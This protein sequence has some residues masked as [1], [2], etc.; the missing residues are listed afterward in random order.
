MVKDA[1]DEK[2]KKKT[3]L[4]KTRRKMIDYSCGGRRETV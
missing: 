4:K 3:C 2:K 1:R